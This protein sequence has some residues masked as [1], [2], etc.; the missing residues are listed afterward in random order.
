MATLNP[1][2]LPIETRLVRLEE[3]VKA[4]VGLL[5]QETDAVKAIDLHLFAKLQQTK[6][7]LFQI[8]HSDIKALLGN[9]DELRT[10]PDHI[11]TRIR[12]WEQNLSI[13]RVE[14]MSTLERAG[15]S[16]TRLRDRIV[17][18]AKDSVIR[19]T[20]KYGANGTLQINSRKVLSTGIQDRV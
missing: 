5:K 7:D 9:K 20:A 3:T 14:N 1:E 12:A 6:A 10:L 19:T 17:H 15:K 8:Y 16:F 4:M 13:G 2:T 11:K 18:L